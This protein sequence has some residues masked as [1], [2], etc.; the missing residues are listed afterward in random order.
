[1]RRRLGI[2]LALG[3]GLLLGVGLARGC[4][5]M[6]SDLTIEVKFSDED[7]ARIDALNGNLKHLTKA[8]DKTLELFGVPIDNAP[9][10]D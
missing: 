2:G 4:M 6:P 8:T 9:S 7:R 10:E 3:T 5:S 1:M